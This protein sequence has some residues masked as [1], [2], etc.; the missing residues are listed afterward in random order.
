M[1]SCLIT[2]DLI[3][4]NRDYEKISKK[5]ETYPNHSH[6]LESVWIVKSDTSSK[7]IR[8]NLKTALDDNDKLFVSK[9]TGECAW[10]KIDEPASQWILDHA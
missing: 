10:R 5:I 7:E 3:G 2:Y 6:I 1:N 4:P 9:L 8:D